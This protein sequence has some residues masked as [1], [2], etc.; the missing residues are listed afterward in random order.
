MTVTALLTNGKL[1]KWIN[2]ILDTGSNVTLVTEE[3]VKALELVGKPCKLDLSGISDN[4]TKCASQLIDLNVKQGKYKRLL[5]KEAQVVPLITNDNL[6]R[7]WSEMM[8]AHKL[9]PYTPPLNAKIN[10]LLGLDNFLLM[11]HK[12]IRFLG[13]EEDENTPIA[14]ETEFG[15]TCIA[16]TKDNSE[17]QSYLNSLQDIPKYC[18]PLEEETIVSSSFKVNAAAAE[19]YRVGEVAFT[20]CQVM[21]Q[22]DPEVSLLTKQEKED[23]MFYH[24][25]YDLLQSLSKFDDFPESDTTTAEEEHCMRLLSETFQI[26]D[27]R[28]YVSQLWRPGQ[29]EAG[30]NNFLYA[31]VR[32]FSV[33]EKLTPE[34]FDS[35]NAIF[36]KYLEQGITREVSV[37]HPEIEDGLY[38]PMFVVHQEKSETTPARPVMDGKCKCLDNKT[39]SINDKCFYAGP[40]LLKRLDQVLIAFREYDYAATMDIGKMFLRVLAPEKYRKYSRFLWVG[41][42]RKTI[43]VF[44]FAGHQFGNVGSPVCAIYAVQKN[45]QNF[46][47]K[48][49]VAVDIVDKN[50]IMDDHLFSMPTWQEARD[51]LNAIIEIHA[52][53]GLSVG[54]VST[55]S[56]DLYKS[57]PKEMATESKNMLDFEKY[58][59]KEQDYPPGEQPP[60]P[61]MRTLGQYWNMVDDTMS[62]KEYSPDKVDRWLKALCLSQQMKIYDP[63]GFLAPVML[64]GKLVLREIFS[65][66][67]TWDKSDYLTEEETVKWEKWLLNLPQLC[68][69]QFKRV[70]KPG[71]PST[72]LRITYHGSADASIH[73]IA[74]VVHICVEF[75]NGGTYTNFVMARCKLTPKNPERSVPKNELTALHMVA[76]LIFQ[77]TALLKVPEENIFLWSDSKTALLWL[78]MDPG[79]L[80][81]FCHNYV[82]KILKKVPIDR[83]RW[84]PGHL[85]PADLATRPR[86]IAELQQQIDLWREGPEFIRKE[87][88]EWP[89]LPELECTEDVLKEV[90]K[91]YR[92][93]ALLNYSFMNNMDENPLKTDRYSSYSK[94]LRVT[95]YVCK[96]ISKLWLRVVAKRLGKV[97]PVPVRGEI[98]LSKREKLEAEA[99][100]FYRHQIQYFADDI[101]RLDKFKQLPI[102]HSIDKLG[103]VMVPYKGMT[104]G[105]TG[106]RH[107]RLC[108]RL[109]AAQH[110]DDRIKRPYLLHP[111]DPLV[112]LLI[113]H[114]HGKV[115]QKMQKWKCE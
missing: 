102:K 10:M 67:P 60:M 48:Y 49:P 8:Q 79:K 32:L 101:R 103:P 96:Y 65:N 92:V 97:L 17:R 74:A 7:D 66:H 107:L 72:Y 53:I 16:V 62:Y 24:R 81:L 57:L 109:S 51:V 36:E 41:K 76:E 85:N 37:K 77:S 99:R 82:T 45:A 33:V 1:E 25:V 38:W 26:I 40:N 21:M 68:Q 112:K 14:V 115:K 43:R 71:L 4:K 58:H 56:L 6:A 22:D 28:A 31:R 98:S 87:Q 110:L 64:E 2:I 106:I 95:A 88:D 104:L 83:I 84:V 30:L 75:K 23:K 63:L 39:I 59:A 3:T 89:A 69:L 44:E 34:Q 29:P 55:N 61:T 105:P 52:N 27:G 35:V 94:L 18:K 19:E 42:D 5:I 50:T 111:A 13:P 20:A 86:T 73:A 93:L 54:K 80:L 46:K 91:E 108:G 12:Q 9:T 70:L 47:K 15:W 100:I 11:V 113:Q 90:K 114:T 78:R